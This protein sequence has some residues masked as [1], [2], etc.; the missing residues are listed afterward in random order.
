MCSSDLERD[1]A[2]NAALG[3]S[4]VLLSLAASVVGVVVI[5]AVGYAFHLLTTVIE[6]RLLRWRRVRI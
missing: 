2:V 1:H 6:A 3:H 4:G 5:G